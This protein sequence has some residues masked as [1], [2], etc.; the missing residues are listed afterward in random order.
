MKL[1]NKVSME[2]A[3]HYEENSLGAFN[4]VLYVTF[5]SKWYKNRWKRKYD[6]YLSEIIADANAE[7]DIEEARKQGAALWEKHRIKLEAKL[8]R[9]SND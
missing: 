9:R 3:L 6:R 5:L 4:Y 8:D 7:D 1:L 2:E